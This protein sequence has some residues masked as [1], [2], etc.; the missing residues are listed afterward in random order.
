MVGIAAL[1]VPLSLP[2]PLSMDENETEYAY[3]SGGVRD[4]YAVTAVE[5]PLLGNQRQGRDE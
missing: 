3:V 1:L 4:K 5:S 2:L